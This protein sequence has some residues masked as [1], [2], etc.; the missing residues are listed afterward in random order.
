M[1]P[2]K[3]EAAKYPDKRAATVLQEQFWAT[4]D[5]DQEWSTHFIRG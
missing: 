5:L 2:L 1:A 4:H 3:L